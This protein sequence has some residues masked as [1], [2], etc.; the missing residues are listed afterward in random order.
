DSRS[1][2]TC[3]RPP[4][5]SV[6][7]SDRNFFPGSSIL[8]AQG[9]PFLPSEGGCLGPCC[10]LV[11]SSRVYELSWPEHESDCSGASWP[12]ARGGNS[13]ITTIRPAPQTGHTCV[14]VTDA[15]NRVG[16]IGSRSSDSGIPTPLSN[17]RHRASFPFR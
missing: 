4:L 6:P 14:G 13:L 10:G 3:A 2:F 15:A 17:S 7:N 16:S 1:D 12:A 5:L 11:S 8:P 9:S